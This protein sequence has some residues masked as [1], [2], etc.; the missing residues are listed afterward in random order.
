MADVNWNAVYG[1]WLVAKHGSFA[2]AA[3][4]APQGSIQALHK[5]VRQLE[6][7]ESLSVKL[8][9]SRGVKGVALTEAGRRVFEVV[10][11]V[12]ESF[13]LQVAALRGED[14]GPLHLAMSAFAAQNFAYEILRTF[15]RSFPKVF[16]RVQ[17][18]E[19]WDIGF[20][21]QSSAVDYGIC[22]SSADPAG[23]LVLARCATPACLVT[24][25]NHP[26]RRGATGWGEIVD[27]PLIVPERTSPLR[28]ALEALLRRENLLARLWIRAELT[29]P[30]LALDV[31]REGTGIAIV[32][33]G[34]WLK[35]CLRGLAV[36]ALPPG[37]PEFSLSLLGRRH[38]YLPQ[39]LREFGQVAVRILKHGAHG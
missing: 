5:R 26:L 20:L 10:D 36:S 30:D 35:G 27:Q 13:D 19:S 15:R 37:L 3:R 2:D 29:T 6:R 8:L 21:V 28:L 14:S 31:V 4:A 12:F 22:S 24:A 11:P 32:L 33:S 7:P 17:V 34:P 39:Y 38:D 1:F 25:R 16:V 23:S 18:R 9:E